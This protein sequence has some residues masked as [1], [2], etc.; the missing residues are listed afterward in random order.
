M[1]RFLPLSEVERATSL[2]KSKLYEMVRTGDF[3]RQK[4]VTGRR[5]AWLASEIESWIRERAQEPLSV[6]QG[7]CHD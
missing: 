5:R 2:K 4:R 7:E 6:D 1:D 3:P